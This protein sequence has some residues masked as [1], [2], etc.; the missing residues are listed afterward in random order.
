M[1]VIVYGDIGAGKST[2]VC[3]AM[4]LLG[5]GGPAGFFT[6]WDGKGR[7]AD[8]LYVETWS[9]GKHPMAR[10]IS[11]P[12]VPGGLSYEPEAGFE[13]VAVA[14]LSGAETGLPV[15]IDELGLIELDSAEF[16]AAVAK[17]FRGSAQV[18]AVV[19]HRAL[20]RW[21]GVIGPENAPHLLKVDSSS[22]DALPEAIAALF[23]S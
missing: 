18:L 2:A 6:H 8:V 13:K 9:G 17:L 5:W 14:S 7:G 3:A 22:R 4:K 19:Q 15:V 12:A 10:R 1:N 23:Q 16:M 20:A 11:K 21:L